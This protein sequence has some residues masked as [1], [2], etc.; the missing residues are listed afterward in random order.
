MTQNHFRVPSAATLLLVL[1][2]AGVLF[3]TRAPSQE[4]LDPT[5][6]DALAEMLPESAVGVGRPISD[7]QAWQAAA[8]QPGFESVVADAER[9]QADPI[10]ELTDDLYLDFSRT[11]NRTRYQRVMG[12]CHA[13]FPALVLA[14]CLENRGRFLAAI[15]EAIRAVCSEKT[16]LYPAHDRSLRNFEGK[17][18][19]IDLGSAAT[20]WN[21]ATAHYWLGEKLSAE[22]RDLIQSELERRCF[23]PFES[24]ASEGEPRLW[25]ATGTNNWNAVCLAGVTGAALAAI[26]SPQRRAFFVAAA[27]KYVQYFLEGFTPDG[28]CSEGLGYWNYGFGHY[29]LLA[30]TIHQA[31][32]GR[33]DLFEEPK[34]PSIARFGVRMEIL[35]GIYPAFADCHVSSR[36]DP[37]LAAFLSRRFGMGLEEVEQQNL[38]L[39]GGPSLS[40]FIQGI[41]GFENSASR[42]P[43]VKGAASEQP[44]REWFPDAGILI[45]RPAPGGGRA[46]GVALK[47]GHNAEH[48][49]HNDVGSFLVALAGQTPLV[50][51]GSEVYTAR[52]FSSKRYESGVLNSFGHP[53]PLVAG[54]LQKSGRS[55]A[56]RVMKTEFS[57]AVDTVV[58]DLRAAYPVDGLEK[59]E[60]TILFSREGAGRLTV[61]DEVRFATTQTFAEALVTFSDWR[62][63]G[64]KELVVG[65]G[66]A[67]VLVELAT[68]GPE[69]RVEAEK[70]EED[71]PGGHIPT[72]LA[73]N[74]A[75]PVA[76]ATV[77]LT[78]TPAETEND[79]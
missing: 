38:L 31:T 1:L 62:Q 40:L 66:P 49:N 69:F 45:C 10:P 57:D 70:I 29:V 35:P 2:A 41:H 56:A 78:I 39:A 42:I 8:A 13:R 64:P 76:A 61:T 50:D 55:A 46:L 17:V 6:I 7:R 53:V 22:T 72:R 3:P 79:Q 65:E 32:G 28:Y 4:P 51:P 12:Q 5:R 23:K 60:R 75:E 67:A 14:E 21:L 68:D 27:E 30:E 19:E 15:D 43:A 52:T 33:V 73:I 37:R 16:W 48:H 54:K 71:L 44:L 36:P 11:G 58:L 59:L 34:V 24:Y 18:I 74:L 20:S 63:A 9:L 25:W 47:G 77:T 26:E